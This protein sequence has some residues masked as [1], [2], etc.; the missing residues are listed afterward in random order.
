[1]TPLQRAI[2]VSSAIA[3][4]ISIMF[5][6]RDGRAHKVTVSVMAWLLFC[7]M[8]C[9]TV[10]A[11]VGQDNLLRWLLVA[12]LFMHSLNIVFAKGNV[13]QIKPCLYVVKRFCLNRFA[14]KK[15]V[16]M[17]KKQESRHA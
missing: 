5:F 17:K 13:N 12:S 9:L 6:N 1:M 8:A 3:A 16:A 7:E 4:A 14:K 15:Y 10:A 11:I 2:I